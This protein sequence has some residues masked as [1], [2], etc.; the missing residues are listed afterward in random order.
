MV[1]VAMLASLCRISPSQYPTLRGVGSGGLVAVRGRNDDVPV[2]PLW[3]PHGVVERDEGAPQPSRSLRGAA[4]LG[5]PLVR[6]LLAARLVGVLATVDPGGPPHAVPVWWA[7]R[8][9]DLVM[10]TSARSR[11]V[12]NLERDARATLVLH[13][14]RPGAEIC[15]ASLRGRVEIVRGSDASALVELVH[16]RYVTPVGLEL[17]EVREFLAFDDVALV[18]RPDAAWTWD[19]RD[20]PAAARLRAGE[21]L[22]LLPTSPRTTDPG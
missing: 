14:S 19:E 2:R 7:V 6:E 9:A 8:G 11:K 16:L 5:D 20:S 13:D 17:P 18:L 4:V 21:A 1:E 3:Y 10:A 15:G 12:R 22:P